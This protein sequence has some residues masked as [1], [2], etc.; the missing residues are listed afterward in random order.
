[1]MPVCDGGSGEVVAMGIYEEVCA[2][3]FGKG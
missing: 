3:A 1:M 2:A